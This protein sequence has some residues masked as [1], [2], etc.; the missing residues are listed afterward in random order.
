[1]S[2]HLAKLRLAGLVKGREEIFLPV[3]MSPAGCPEAMVPELKRAVNEL[4]FRAAH[5][6]P[7]CGTKNLDD[8]ACFPYYAAA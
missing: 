3:A 4:G 6:V 5:L 2:Q 7:Y 1:M 8:P